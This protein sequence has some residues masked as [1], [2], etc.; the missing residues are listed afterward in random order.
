VKREQ[1]Q[2]PPTRSEPLIDRVGLSPTLGT[3]VYST[4][5]MTNLKF[6]L[7]T[8]LRAPFVTGFAIVSLALGIGA[9]AAVF[10]ILHQMLRSSLPVLEPDRLVN[11]SAPGPKPDSQSCNTAGDCEAVFSYA[12]FRDLESMQTVFTGVAAHRA[13]DANLSFDGQT[14]RG[15]GTYV[16]GGYFPLLGLRAAAGRLLTP[17]DDRQIGESPVVVVSYAYWTRHFG[18]REDIVNRKMIINGQPL[19]IIGVTP[20][21]FHCRHAITSEVMAA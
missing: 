4:N 7:R 13:F 8:L 20:R 12:M 21:G 1:N 18:R 11:L 3:L 2:R 5:M 10:S 19:T 14:I 15:G 16:S 6:A 9:S 17:D